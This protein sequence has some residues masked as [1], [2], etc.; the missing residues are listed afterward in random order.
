MHTE[1]LVRDFEAELPFQLPC[2]ACEDA[3]ACCRSAAE[4]G[5]CG[6]SY[7]R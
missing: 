2:K 4:D 7:C 1:Y 5:G 6:A 3:N